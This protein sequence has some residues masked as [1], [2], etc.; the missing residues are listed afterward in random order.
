MLLH[1]KYPIEVHVDETRQMAMVTPP[2][3]WKYRTL[4][5]YN[6][7]SSHEPVYSMCH[8]SVVVFMFRFLFVFVRLRACYLQIHIKR[9]ASYYTHS[10]VHW[11]PPLFLMPLPID[12]IVF[13]TE[14]VATF[15]EIPCSSF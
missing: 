7:V 5:D 8:I 1:Y 12:V 4:H 13:L 9:L 14:F 2:H 11:I 3:T 10:F 15:P 6:T